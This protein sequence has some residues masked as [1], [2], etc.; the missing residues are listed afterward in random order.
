MRI[1]ILRQKYNKEMEINLN[2]VRMFP[3]LVG[4]R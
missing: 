1:N 4:R 3:S 2:A